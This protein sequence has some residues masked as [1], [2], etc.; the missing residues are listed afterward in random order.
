[1]Q[2]RR[3]NDHIEVDLLRCIVVG[4]S[5]DS[6]GKLLLITILVESVL[7]LAPELAAVDPQ[8]HL[9]HTVSDDELVLNQVLD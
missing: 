6:G 7:A 1:M 4:G 8:H 5:H 3:G 9:G 2:V